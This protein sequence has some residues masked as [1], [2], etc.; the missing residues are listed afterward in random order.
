MA[1]FKKG[2]QKYVPNNFNLYE[3]ETINNYMAGRNKLFKDFNSEISLDD[4]GNVLD[5]KSLDDSAEAIIDSWRR[6]TLEGE[7]KVFEIGGHK[8][9]TEEVGSSPFLSSLIKATQK[10][11]TSKTDKVF[12]LFSKLGIEN[13]DGEARLSNIGKENYDDLV[14]KLSGDIDWNEPINLKQEDGT[15]TQFNFRNKSQLDSADVKNLLSFLKQSPQMKDKVVGD[16]VHIKPFDFDPDL[17]VERRM[18]EDQKEIE[19]SSK[20]I[21]KNIA[22]AMSQGLTAEEVEMYRSST[23]NKVSGTVLMLLEAGTRGVGFAYSSILPDYIGELP[24][25]PSTKQQNFFSADAGIFKGW[26][27]AVMNKANEREREW[28]KNNPDLFQYKKNREDTYSNSRTGEKTSKTTDE[29]AERRDFLNKLENRVPGFGM[30]FGRM[31]DAL[32]EA[33]IEKGGSGKDNKQAE[34][35]ILTS[36][37]VELAAQMK[38]ELEDELESLPSNYDVDLHSER[39]FATHPL[40]DAFEIIDERVKNV[41]S[42]I[43]YSGNKWRDSV[44]GLIRMAED[45][46]LAFVGMGSMAKKLVKTARV[47]KYTKFLKN[48]DAHMGGARAKWF[49]DQIEDRVPFAYDLIGA[50]KKSPEVKNML[51]SVV[52]DVGEQAKLYAGSIKQAKDVVSPA[53]GMIHGI[54]RGVTDFFANKASRKTGI[55][56]QEFFAGIEGQVH[57]H[58]LRLPIV[59]QMRKFLKA[60]LYAKFASGIGT[61]RVAFK[62]FRHALKSDLPLDLTEAQRADIIKQTE[63][64][65]Q[66]GPIDAFFKTKTDL[67]QDKI[68]RAQNNWQ[69]FTPQ[70]KNAGKESIGYELAHSFFKENVSLID[71]EEA[72]GKV[73]AKQT[74]N[75]GDARD[76]MGLISDDKSYNIIRDAMKR[77]DA[78]EE[79]KNLIG[80]NESQFIYKLEDTA[81]GVNIKI[82]VDPKAPNAEKLKEMIGDGVEFSVLKDKEKLNLISELD[83]VSKDSIKNSNFSKSK[84]IKLN[85]GS[86]YVVDSNG[87]IYKSGE[88]DNIVGFVDRVPHVMPSGEVKMVIDPKTFTQNSVDTLLAKQK[89]MMIAQNID[90]L[91]ESKK[92]VPILDEAGLMTREAT[93][94]IAQEMEKLWT[95][96]YVE[97][98]KK[99]KVIDMFKGFVNTGDPQAVAEVASEMRKA[100]QSSS[101]EDLRMSLRKALKIQSEGVFDKLG[102]SYEM[103]NSLPLKAKNGADSAFIKKAKKKLSRKEM[104]SLWEMI[105]LSRKGEYGTLAEAMESHFA[106][107]LPEEIDA[108]VHTYIANNTKNLSYTEAWDMMNKMRSMERRAGLHTSSP[109][110]GDLTTYNET[111]LNLTRTIKDKIVGGM[112]HK[113]VLYNISPEQRASFFFLMDARRTKAALLDNMAHQFGEY[114]GTILGAEAMA[115]KAG[116]AQELMNLAA[117][118][119]ADGTYNNTNSAFQTLYR[120]DNLLEETVD[121]KTKMNYFQ[122]TGNARFSE[123]AYWK[124]MG[125]RM[126]YYKDASLET[127]AKGVGEKQIKYELVPDY[128]LVHGKMNRIETVAEAHETIDRGFNP[129]STRKQKTYVSDERLVKTRA[130]EKSASRAQAAQ[131]ASKALFGLLYNWKFQ[132]ARAAYSGWT[133]SDRQKMANVFAKENEYD[134]LKAMESGKIDVV[135]KW[136]LTTADLSIGLSNIIGEDV[137]MNVS[138]VSKKYAYYVERAGAALKD[139]V[140][141]MDS[142]FKMLDPK[143]IQKP[144]QDKYTKKE[145]IKSDKSSPLNYAVG[146]RLL[147][148]S[149]GNYIVLAR[150]IGKND[151]EEYYY[152]GDNFEKSVKAFSSKDRV[153]AKRYANKLSEKRKKLIRSKKNSRGKGTSWSKQAFSE[154]TINEQLRSSM[155][156][157]YN[158]ER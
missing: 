78:T 56:Q 16:E 136:L 32:K 65:F 137:D 58:L 38:E 157:D 138:P 37:R 109:R 98:D 158:I 132:T 21:M 83:D 94:E 145:G 105:G 43:T 142:Q 111:L 135:N 75:Y 120:W 110:G 70:S 140:V 35:Y 72:I 133:M 7:Q 119:V 8:Y 100:L 85:D 76:Y 50:A 150:D 93:Q 129:L 139:K 130:A 127:T 125:D 14:R 152:I 97:T 113:D 122:R 11:P 115:K 12:D 131:R 146:V 74:M 114:G 118:E 31:N 73:K 60:G 6:D 54:T 102:I 88:P 151:N 18:G 68:N 77:G 143:I 10:K 95:L 147:E 128:K 99:N 41:T 101:K 49:I 71:A 9:N 121:D 39:F 44:I 5:V 15:V 1:I 64:W 4:D 55:A 51:M 17:G 80:Q 144:I 89:A 19:S 61:G 104:S 84:T 67:A 30:M 156:G 153:D 112:K 53:E 90:L 42:D 126:G 20:G 108:L 36:M 62:E 63:D 66:G 69:V 92:I 141:G 149:N 34:I 40:N 155:G 28:I 26:R 79:I 81:T 117:K 22:T 123:T 13:V 3:D 116:K 33:D 23:L 124:G 59:Y 107:I 52:R 154:M 25:V 46:S 24:L 27:D 48:Y 86:D 96:Q 148:T 91:P 134:A 82:N 87:T 29:I 57:S 47:K 106:N 45:P 2:N 103:L